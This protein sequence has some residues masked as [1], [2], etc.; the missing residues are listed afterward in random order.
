MVSRA[1]GIGPKLAQRIINELAQKLPTSLTSGLVPVGPGAADG[2]EGVAA[3][4]RQ[5][6]A[7]DA[8]SAL[9]NLGYSRTEAFSAVTQTMQ[10]E[11][12][13]DVSVLIALALKQ[14]RQAGAKMMADNQQDRLVTPERS[15]P[16]I[17]SEF[18][19]GLAALSG[20]CR[21]GAGACKSGDI[22]WCCTPA[23]RANGSHAAAWPAGLGKTTMAQII[24]GE[25]GVGFRATSGPVI[26]RAGDLQHC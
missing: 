12:A 18:G 22:Y 16:L 26:A 25:L 13:K 23:R 11:E 2:A 21:A 6:L 10:N 3:G 4:T 14:L 20:V 7:Q 17:P 15:R 9:V 5:L 24:S 19:S 8:L 1:D